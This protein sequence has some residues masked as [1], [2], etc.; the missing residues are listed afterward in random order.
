MRELKY[1]EK[2]L[3][4]KVNLEKWKKTNTEREQ[5]VSSKYLLHNRDEYV[6]YNRL[7][8]MIR[9]MAESLVRLVENDCT[10]QYLTKKLIN[11]LYS[12]GI[13][14]EKRLSDC[15]KITVSDV[16]KRRLPIILKHLGMVENF[17]DADKFVQQGHVK[18]GTK[19]C[20]N[21]AILISKNKEEFVK[22]D[23]GSKIKKKIDAQNNV[24]DDFKYY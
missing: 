17:K 7:V 13:I 16:C 1:H 4:K 8:G 14:S 9:K 10:R 23:D 12:L 21:P 6:K 19:I 5:L 11:K 20:N 15:T 18:I 2:K 22:W 24:F 3:L